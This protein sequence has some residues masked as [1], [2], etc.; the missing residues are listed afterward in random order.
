MESIRVRTVA[1]LLAGTVTTLVLI[2]IGG[3]ARTDMGTTVL[4]LPAVEV[5]ATR[6]V[7]NPLI[8]ESAHDRRHD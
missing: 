7:P 4:V 1:A 6:P 8:A 5:L 3:L 2:G